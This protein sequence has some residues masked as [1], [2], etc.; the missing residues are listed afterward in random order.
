MTTEKKAQ[1]ER[2]GTDY[3]IL[4]EGADTN[5]EGHALYAAIGNTTASNDISAIN[6]I[7]GNE[8]TA[9]KY[10]AIPS[11]SFRVREVTVSTVT[12]TKVN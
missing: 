11:R 8:P 3:V 12:Q 1:P 7:L 6:A 5:Q 9:G 2:F 10:I 4:R